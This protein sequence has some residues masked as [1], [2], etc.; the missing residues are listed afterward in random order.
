MLCRK[1]SGRV[2]FTCELF[3]ILLFNHDLVGTTIE[4]V[5]YPACKLDTARPILLLL[6]LRILGGLIFPIA[7]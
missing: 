4:L 1:K 2:A 7:P 3:Q 6:K 5:D